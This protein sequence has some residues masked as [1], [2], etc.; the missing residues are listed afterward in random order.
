LFETVKGFS[1]KVIG[2]PKKKT[3]ASIFPV[4]KIDGVVSP[5]LTK[6]FEVQ[7]SQQEN[8]HA[9]QSVPLYEKVF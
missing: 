1:R 5:E 9:S 4:A 6:S 7:M 3:L 2:A 8:P